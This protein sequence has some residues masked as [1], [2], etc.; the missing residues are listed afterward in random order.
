MHIAGDK[1]GHTKNVYDFEFQG[2]T[3]EICK[4]F[5]HFRYTNLYQALKMLESLQRS[6]LY[7][8]YNQR[9]ERSYLNVFDLHFQGQI[10]RSGD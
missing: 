10:S 8:V 4:L 1:Q 3:F 9:Y 5:Q 2:Q 6:C 7:D